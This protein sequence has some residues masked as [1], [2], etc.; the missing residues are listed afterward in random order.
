MR[1]L[2]GIVTV[3]V[4]AVGFYAM[5]KDRESRTVK[6]EMLQ[7]VDQLDLSPTQRG[8]VRL[9]VESVHGPAFRKAL[10]V[11]RARGTRFDAVA[12]K[13]EVFA[14]LI[15]RVRADEPQLAEKL[16]IQQHHHQL[17]IVEH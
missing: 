13:D 16:S 8:R 12:Y 2:L 15:D 11:T 17:K 9:L 3:C 4:F 7:L 1:K 6:L 10:D 5:M 14:R